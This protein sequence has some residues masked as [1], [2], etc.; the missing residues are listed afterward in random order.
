MHYSQ[1]NKM[2]SAFNRRRRALQSLH[3]KHAH[4]AATY[5]PDCDKSK[6][7]ARRYAEELRRMGA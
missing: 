3:D 4:N 1:H 7:M 6:R 2:T 5:G